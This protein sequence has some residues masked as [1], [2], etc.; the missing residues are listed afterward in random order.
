MH[1][2]KKVNQD[3]ARYQFEISFTHTL[4]ICMVLGT[5]KKWSFSWAPKIQEP[6]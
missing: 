6:N 5:A 1:V 2:E 3:F 4:T